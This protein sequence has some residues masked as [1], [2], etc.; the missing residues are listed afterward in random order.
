MR[1]ELLT[2]ET[3][4]NLPIGTIVEVIWS[5]GNGPH[6]YVVD[7]LHH[8]WPRLASLADFTRGAAGMN[9]LDRYIGPKPLTEARIVGM[10]EK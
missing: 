10:V 1:G 4:L 3:C 8:G 2:S 5:G 6:R 9:W 7:M